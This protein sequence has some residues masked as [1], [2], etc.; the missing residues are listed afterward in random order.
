LL[1]RLHRP[2]SL[3]AHRWV[4]FVTDACCCCSLTDRGCH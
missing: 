2:R 4:S 1:R 3:P